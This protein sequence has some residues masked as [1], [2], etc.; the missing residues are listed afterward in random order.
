MHRR[1]FVRVLT[2]GGA[3][4]VVPPFFSGC[5]SGPS[6]AYQAWNGPSPALADEDVR[7]KVVSLGLLAPSVANLQPWWVS[8]KHPGILVALEPHR[9]LPHSD[10]DL[11]QTMVSHGAFIEALRLAAGMYG[12]AA[13]V[14]P[15]PLGEPSAENRFELP[16]AR[17]DLE[18]GG[19][20]DAL[21]EHLLHRRTNRRR[22]RDQA[23]AQEDLD[24]LTASLPA[25][26]S[27]H[28]YTSPETRSRIAQVVME[29]TA[30]SL[31]RTENYRETVSSLRWSDAETESMR[32]GI[33]LRHLGLSPWAE[34]SERI[35]NSRASA[36]DGSMK[37]RMLDLARQQSESAAA[38]GV[39]A[40]ASQGR[41][42]ELAAGAALLRVHLAATARRI[43]FQPLNAPLEGRVAIPEDLLPSS[44]VP[45]V[46][47]RIGFA[48]ETPPAPRRTLFEVV[49]L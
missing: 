34:W 7:L 11:H 28:W 8:L 5:Q 9:F 47:F 49:Q 29:A 27:V 14:V 2:A 18:H 10:P 42:A 13:T 17:L 4:L 38:F 40:T 37:D 44:A 32:D 31:D 39:L 41:G 16:V 48:D 46:L 30:A 3:A 23:V 15:F 33:P 43:A 45:H 1:T 24:A 36:A 6:V 22:F 35:L 19:G 25:H 26:V 20:R 21:A 12:H